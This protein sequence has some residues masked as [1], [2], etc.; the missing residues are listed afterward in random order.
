ML[1]LTV[2]LFPPVVSIVMSPFVETRLMPSDSVKPA[3]ELISTLPEPFAV[4]SPVTVTLAL[5]I[6]NVIGA[7]SW[8][9]LSTFTV[10][11]PPTIVSGSVNAAE[12]I[13]TAPV[14]AERPM[15][16]LE[17]PSTRRPISVSS[18]FSVPAPP[19]IPMVVVV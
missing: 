12:S 4:R 9:V 10:V 15:V 17:K 2:R 13:F 7:L 19:P 5:F 18:I 3:P 8:L 1:P 6:F 16:M 11:S 14:P